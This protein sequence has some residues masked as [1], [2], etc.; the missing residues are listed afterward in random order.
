MYTLLIFILTIK[1]SL[2]QCPVLFRKSLPFEQWV[3]ISDD[4]PL[5][6]TVYVDTCSKNR[7]CNFQG[8]LGKYIWPLRQD[9]INGNSSNYRFKY[10][11]GGTATFGYL[12]AYCTDRYHLS[13]GEKLTNER[14]SSD[15]QCLTGRCHFGKWFGYGLNEPCSVNGEWAINYWWSNNLCTPVV[16]NGA[17]CTED[18]ECDIENICEAGSNTCQYAFQETDGTVVR[19]SRR[20]VSG[21][22]RNNDGATGQCKTTTHT[23]QNG[24]DLTNNKWDPTINNDWR[25]RDNNGRNRFTPHSAFT[26]YAYTISEP[27]DWIWVYGNVGYCMSYGD[28]DWITMHS[29]WETTI[30]P[31]INN[32]WH[33]S[34]R[35]NPIAW[36]DC[37]NGLS[38]SQLAYFADLLY[39][40][41]NNAYLE[42]DTI[43]SDFIATVS[44]FS[45]ENWKKIGY[46][47]NI[48]II[49]LAVIF[50]SILI[51]FQL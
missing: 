40:N 41:T 21:V 33:Q 7:V 3:Q 10:N 43:Y 9:D 2:S 50:W 6:K 11:N 5:N 45:P 18:D 37:Q 19:D 48:S 25:L 4:Y 30:R 32:T 44:I 14:C 36:V 27:T 39:R 26:A 23:R 8:P 20:C 35:F 46:V 49:L 28:A 12:D 34:R 31:S 24:V 47:N 15:N 13:L 17:A 51:L 22:K 29:F 38:E 42:E 1:Y 16:A